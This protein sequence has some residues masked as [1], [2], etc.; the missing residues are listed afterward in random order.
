[1]NY[2]VIT[3]EFYSE[4]VN[5]DDP[6]K[7]KAEYLIITSP[8]AI[9]YVFPLNN[10]EVVRTLISIENPVNF[11]MAELAPEL[12]GEYEQKAL[13]MVKGTPVLY[14]YWAVKAVTM[15]ALQNR[16]YSL[17]QRMLLMNFAYKSVQGML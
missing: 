6:A 4:L 16:K 3:P 13:E 12:R 5:K 7:S 9:E 15:N 1:M 14:H 2:S 8:A 10:P 11:K 17:D